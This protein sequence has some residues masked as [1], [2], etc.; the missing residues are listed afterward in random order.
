ML[1]VFPDGSVYICVVGGQGTL[2]VT[3]AVPDGGSLSAPQSGFKM[4]SV[5]HLVLSLC[6]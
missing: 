2:K 5:F 4:L 6:A 1:F 3:A